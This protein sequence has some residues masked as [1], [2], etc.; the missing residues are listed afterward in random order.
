M[1]EPQREVGSAST[2]EGPTAAQI[3]EQIA[4]K[5]RELKAS[6]AAKPV[7]PAPEPAPIAPPVLPVPAPDLPEANKPS[8]AA[9]DSGA[10]AL[11]G[12]TGNDKPE[13][14]TWIEKKGFKSTEDM[15]RS[16]RE[17]ERE[18]HS[19]ARGNGAIT[20]PPAPPEP[21][22]Q[23]RQPSYAPPAPNLEELA[24]RYNMDPS[25]LER[26]APLAADIA[27]NHVAR[28]LTPL[29][30][31]ITQLRRDNARTAEFQGLKEDPAFADP[32]VQ[33]E[34]H[35]I[36]QSNP[37]ILQNEPA[38]YRFAFNEAL[39]TMGRRILEGSY[40]PG[41][42]VPPVSGL[43][44]LP[45]APPR[46]AGGSG[47][48]SGAPSGIQPTGRLSQDEFNRLPAAEQRKI[49]AKMGLVNEQEV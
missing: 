19:R 8:Q 18:L 20:P 25:D 33:F 4:E 39:R 16:M 14:K 45:T 15:V 41:P 43:S 40:D 35:Q 27:A 48:G 11:P 26:V 28:E 12:P 38:P 32:R 2:L 7:A 6:A 13:W 42:Q 1:S 9:P 37:S 31:E 29:R 17:L 34:M 5:Q 46:T 49:L 22:Y 47:A 3:M 10:A 23:P 36:L 30:A 44:G 21:S 24:K